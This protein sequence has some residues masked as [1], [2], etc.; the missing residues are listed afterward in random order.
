[1]ISQV[2]RDQVAEHYF[3]PSSVKD[4]LS[5]GPVPLWSE[6]SLG[7]NPNTKPTQISRRATQYEGVVSALGTGVAV[8]VTLQRGFLNR[9][10]S[11]VGL[12]ILPTPALIEPID[13]PTTE[14]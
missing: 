2:E 7:L 9:T 1:M 3:A 14:Q 6:G 4:F 5:G 11:R 12:D 8:E 13:S 10:L